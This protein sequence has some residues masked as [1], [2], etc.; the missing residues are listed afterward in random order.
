MQSAAAPNERAY[1]AC[2]KYFHWQSEAR[3]KRFCQCIAIDVRFDKFTERQMLRIDSDL[4]RYSGFGTGRER[5]ANQNAYDT[6][7]YRNANIKR[8]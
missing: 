2:R 5:I 8:R 7:F 6:C 1:Q 3:E 4:A